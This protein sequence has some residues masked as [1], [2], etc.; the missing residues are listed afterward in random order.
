MKIFVSG[1]TGF[2]GRAFCAL[3]TSRGHK[4][5]ALC[6]NADAVLPPGV[7]KITG[8]LTN[9]PW[10]EV[11]AFAPDAVLHLAWVA[12]PGVYLTSP[13]NQIWLEES[14][15]WLTKLAAMGVPYISGAGTCIEYAASEEPLDE[16]SSTLAPVFAYSRAKVSLYQWLC[17]G[18]LGDSVVWSWLRIFYPYGPGEHSNRICSSLI[19]QLK[20]GKSLA[21]RTPHSVKDYIFVDDVASAVCLALEAALSGPVNIGTGNGI[22]ILDLAL[23][24]ATLVGADPGLVQVA[25]ELSVDPTPVMI[26]ATERIRSLGWSPST[27][28]DQGLRQLHEKLQDSL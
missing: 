6:Q 17:D 9:T 7:E 20:A 2:I 28:L 27:S 16:V 5:L 1:A 24:V 23:K 15:A 13:E 25:E 26:A 4:L 19:Q 8:N 3:A 18:G 22:S 14:K 12:T 11:A 21:L 10:A